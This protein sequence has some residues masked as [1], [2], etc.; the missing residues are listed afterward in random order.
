M[1]PSHE[2]EVA[3]GYEFEP[4][5][6]FVKVL[7]GEDPEHLNAYD[8]SEL[9]T[10]SFSFPVSFLTFLFLHIRS[11]GDSTKKNASCENPI[12]TTGRRPPARPGQGVLSTLL[13]RPQWHTQRSHMA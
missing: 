12:W 4:P 5:Y 7:V 10:V 1:V 8:V 9:Y 6:P 3:E 11:S 2:E 13:Y